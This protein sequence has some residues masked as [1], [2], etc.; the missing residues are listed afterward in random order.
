MSS[1][2]KSRQ[3][4]QAFITPARANTEGKRLA[5]F[6]IYSHP[7]PFKKGILSILIFAIKKNKVL[8]SL[9]AKKT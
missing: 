8:Y 1:G 4:P 7:P 5:D 3:F 6:N 9:T 2:Q